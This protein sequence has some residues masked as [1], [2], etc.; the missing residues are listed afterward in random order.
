MKLFTTMSCVSQFLWIKEHL[1]VR[2]PG[3]FVCYLKVRM[4]NSAKECV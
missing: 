3:A 4:S 1:C 2:L